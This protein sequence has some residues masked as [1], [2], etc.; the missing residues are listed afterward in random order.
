M[1]WIIL[2]F[3]GLCEV[4]FNI[5][6]WNNQMTSRSCKLLPGLAQAQPAWYRMLPFAQ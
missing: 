3:A 2:I 6:I 5:I 1:N 4:V